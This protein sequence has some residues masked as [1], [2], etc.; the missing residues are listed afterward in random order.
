MSGLQR[1]GDGLDQCR[2]LCSNSVHTA[3]PLIPNTTAMFHLSACT[4]NQLLSWLYNIT[5]RLYN[6]HEGCG[7]PTPGPDI[8]MGYI[9]VVF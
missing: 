2:E 4:I 7:L 5:T 1:A 8:P 3:T 6:A 9:R